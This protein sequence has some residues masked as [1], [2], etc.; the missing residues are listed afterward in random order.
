LRSQ[1]TL[2]AIVRVAANEDLAALM[3]ERLI[4]VPRI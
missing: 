2:V 4:A 3:T 1:G